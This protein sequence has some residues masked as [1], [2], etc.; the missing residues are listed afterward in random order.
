MAAFSDY[1]ENKLVNT[2]LRGENFTAPTTV[3]L[4]LFTSDPTDADTGSELADSAYI[5]QDMAKGEAVSTGWAAPSNGVTSNA[6]LIQFPPI[7]DG[8]VV[9][10]H[11]ALYDAQGGGNMLYHSAL[12]TSKTMEISDVVSFD[13]GAL[14]V[15]L[16]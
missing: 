4:A 13:I 7:A 12:T 16:R 3:Y 5:R 1:L 10:T 14:T 2:T 8:T 9:I 15:T 6:K 11:Y